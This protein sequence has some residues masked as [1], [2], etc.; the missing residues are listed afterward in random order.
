MKKKY[1]LTDAAKASALIHNGEFKMRLP[2]YVLNEDGTKTI[3]AGRSN[4]LITIDVDDILSVTDEITQRGLE[5]LV[6]PSFPPGLDHI[7]PLF[8][9]TTASANKDLDALL[10][11]SVQ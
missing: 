4:P 9:S 3:R 6:G 1:K 11:E 10:K 2:S 7:G 5:A 8:K